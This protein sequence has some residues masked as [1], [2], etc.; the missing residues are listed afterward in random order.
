MYEVQLVDKLVPDARGPACDMVYQ[1]TDGLR[2]GKKVLIIR[3]W[4]ETHDVGIPEQIERI[5]R[6]F[7]QENGKDYFAVFTVP[8]SERPY[9]GKITDNML[10]GFWEFKNS[11]DEQT[12]TS[13]N[14]EKVKAAKVVGTGYLNAPLIE[15][16]DF[17]TYIAFS[18][19]EETGI[20][21]SEEDE[22]APLRIVEKAD[23]RTTKNREF[24][25][26]EGIYS[27]REIVGGGTAVF[28][29]KTFEPDRIPYSQG[30]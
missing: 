7:V 23:F 9:P 2:Q 14:F 20:L 4:D 19:G 25:F 29:Y 11:G 5:A 8:E 3:D 6:K 26:D 27:L 28:K 22:D 18:K 24:E 10:N 12:M 16:V 13:L 15:D 1:V 21:S 17:Q 30:P